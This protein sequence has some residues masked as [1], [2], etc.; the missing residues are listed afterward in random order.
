MTANKLSE[1]SLFRSLKQS[2]KGVECRTVQDT[3]DTFCTSGNFVFWLI[4]VRRNIILCPILIYEL[5]FGNIFV[6]ARSSQSLMFCLI[7]L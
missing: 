5:M 3:H 4:N 7:Y 2:P 6:P 1:R